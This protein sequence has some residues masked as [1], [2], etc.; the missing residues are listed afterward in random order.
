MTNKNG[1][2]MHE[3]NGRLADVPK[4][5]SEVTL[6]PFSGIQILDFGFND[7]DLSSKRKYLEKTIDVQGDQAKRMLIPLPDNIDEAAQIEASKADIDLD[8]YTIDEARALA[9]FVGLWVPVPVLRIKRDSGTKRGERYD[10]GPTSWARIRVVALHQP[11]PKTGHTHRVQLALDTMLGA[12]NSEDRYIAPDEDDVLN[13]REFRFVSAPNAISWFLNDPRQHE[14]RAPTDQQSWVSDWVR[15]LFLSFKEREAEEMGRRF[16]E[17][18]LKYELEHWARYLQFLATI[19]AAISLPK[20]R[21]VDSVSTRDSV[22]P[23][24]VDLVIDIGNSRTCGIFI[25]RFPDGTELDLTRSFELSLRDLSRPEFVYS[26]LI[27]SRVEFAELTF[28]KEQYASQSG[29]GNGFLWPSFVRVGPEA[30]RLTQGE[31]GTETTSGLSSPK[32]YLWDVNPIRQDWRF[33][34]HTNPTVLPR[35]VRAIMQYLNEAGDVL[36]EVEREVA[37]GIR[38]RNQVSLAQ[39]IRP[40]FSRSS[41]YTFMLGELIA[42]ALMQIN[43][44]AGRMRRNQ[45]DLPRRLARIILTLP[46]ATPVQEQKII[47]SRAN[48]ALDLV[49]KRLGIHEGASNISRKPELIVEWDEASCTQLVYLFSE[50]SQRFDGHVNRY[51]GLKGQAREH[52]KSKERL[53]S[54]RVACIDIGGGTTDLMITTYFGRDNALLD[55][56][57]TFREGF[58]IAGDD[59]LR[60]VISDIILPEITRAT[61]AAGASGA[62][63]RLRDLFAGNLGSGDAQMMQQRRQFVI[64]VL[65]PLAVALISAAETASDDMKIQIA[66]ADVLGTYADPAHVAEI[67]QMDEAPE[68]RPAPRR[69]L[70]IAQSVCAYLEGPMASQGAKDWQILNFELS[71]PG[72]RIDM[73]VRDVFHGALENML[74]VI[75]HLGTDIVLLTGR[76]SRLPVIRDMVEETMVVP[77]DRVVSMHGYRT[78][79][80]YP[81]RNLRTQRIDDPKST[82]A[83]GGMLIALSG[84][85]MPNFKVLT[86]SFRMRSTARF[87]GI[88]EK[89][90]QIQT[91]KV[92]FHPGNP[93]AGERANTAANV[94]LHNPALIGFRQLKLDRWTTTPIYQLDFA[95][96]ESRG[97]P[98][99]FTVTLERP[100]IDAPED[101]MSLEKLQ[102]LEALQE[103]LTVGDVFNGHGDDIGPAQVKLMLQ[104]I[105]LQSDYWLDTG[106]VG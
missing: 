14:G 77:P 8:P 50:I 21:F 90:D 91:E 18:K 13:P 31:M 80:W 104:T 11:D 96:V 49:W 30:Q 55:P 84:S 48:A 53:P 56:D 9:P 57:Q 25:E 65:Q 89:N 62:A 94:T 34:N 59:L 100:E 103:V 93:A 1:A 33:H 78:D 4:W 87:I 51:I 81:F 54:V 52:P 74:E 35:N 75:S 101:E 45:A 10:P 97:M 82:V 105:G 20:F 16:T 95:S 23:V 98:T 92:L 37:A 3:T 6:V 15:E 26:G 36:D 58:R 71:V 41:V 66:A 7:A 39:A 24:E 17:D 85:R 44:P 32:R 43:D 69:K 22:P 5:Q 63:G 61:E 46:T 64:Q 68:D 70:N 38:Q 47:R 79:D 2:T 19:D 86:D 60:K 99:P 29:R 76:P 42:Q 12:K 102:H 83:V 73:V 28:G 88:M 106:I 72:S 27:E 40:R 67:A